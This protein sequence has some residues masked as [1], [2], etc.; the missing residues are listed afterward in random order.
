MLGRAGIKLALE[1]RSHCDTKGH[2]ER[3]QYE[4]VLGVEM[5]EAEGDLTWWPLNFISEVGDEA[6]GNRGSV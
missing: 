6:T 5:R 1:K 4:F 2:K 3:C